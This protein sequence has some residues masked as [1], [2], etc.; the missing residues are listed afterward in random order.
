VKILFKC[1]NDSCTTDDQYHHTPLIYAAANGRVEVVRVLLEGGVNVERINANQRT[2]LHKA[3]FF[4]HLEVCRLLLDWEAKVDPVDKFK[5]TPLHWAAKAGNLS[6]VKLLVERGADV[7]L[8]NN[9][10]LTASESARSV[11]KADVAE[12]LDS[13]SRG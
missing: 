10:G 7:R 1:T 8:K 13:V 2:A 12:W 6:V 4:G 11:G 9:K 3:A 5:H